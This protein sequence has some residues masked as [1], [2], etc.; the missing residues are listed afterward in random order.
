MRSWAVRSFLVVAVAGLVVAFAV[1]VGDDRDTAFTLGVA[2]GLPAAELRPGA[3][4]CQTPVPVAEAFDG[5]RMQVGTYRRKGSPLTVSI[6]TPDSGREIAA[7][8]VPGGYADV[9][10]LGVTLDSTVAPGQRVA[11]CVRNAGQRKVAIYGGPELANVGT[12][13]EIGGRDQKTDMTLVFT[14]P[15]SS[16][17]SQTSEIFERA[18]LFRPVWIGPWAYWL[19]AGL[20]LVAVPAL[21][22]RSLR[23]ASVEDSLPQSGSQ[24]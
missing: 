13:V 23:A 9:S 1:V 3:E 6:R 11:V 4:G 17:L 20:I 10:Q 18:S 24:P 19:L 22:A 2:P 7:A 14:R 8:R 15:P 5:V 16:L 21:L 12:T